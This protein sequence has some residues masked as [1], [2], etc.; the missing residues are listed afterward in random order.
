M[1]ACVWGEEGGG[2]ECRRVQHVWA[3]VGEVQC[4]GSLRSGTLAHTG[5]HTGTTRAGSRCACPPIHSNRAMSSPTPTHHQHRHVQEFR[6]QD[7]DADGVVSYDQFKAA[8][9]VGAGRA[10]LQEWGPVRRSA[11]CKL[12]SKQPPEQAQNN[13]SSR[14]PSPFAHPVTRRPHLP[15]LPLLRLQAID[16]R[17]DLK[18]SDE[19]IRRVFREADFG[20]QGRARRGRGRGSQHR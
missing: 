20:E 18:F 11:P 17:R 5:V 14:Q 2:R 16:T 6:R 4:Q 15:L 12:Q 8:M 9:E 19:Y 10:L 3:W 13:P 1:R 7:T